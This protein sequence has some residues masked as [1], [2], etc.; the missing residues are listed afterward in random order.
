MLYGFEVLEDRLLMAASVKKGTL[1]FTGTGGDDLINVI[2]AGGGS[3]QVTMDLNADG[4]ILDPDEDVTFNDIRRVVVESG[5]GN[6]TV[7]VNGLSLSKHMT[8][9]TGGGNDD[10][11]LGVTAANSLGK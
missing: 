4:D 6:D 9:N 5:E 10:V 8:I 11:I 2:G 3:V 7:V 1:T